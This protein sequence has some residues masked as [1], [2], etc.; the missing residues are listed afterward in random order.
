MLGQAIG[1]G[2]SASFDGE[3]ELQ[4]GDQAFELLLVPPLAGTD[5]ALDRHASG[6]GQSQQN[7]AVRLLDA[8]IDVVVW[9]K[10]IAD[11]LERTVHAGT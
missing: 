11:F 3:A 6:V 7:A 2:L 4:A 1:A 5:E 10:H 8:E 9:L